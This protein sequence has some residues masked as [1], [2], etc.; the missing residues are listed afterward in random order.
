ML[1]AGF[2]LSGIL[3]EAK[4]LNYKPGRADAPCKLADSH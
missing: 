4:S 3:T 2:S 1:N